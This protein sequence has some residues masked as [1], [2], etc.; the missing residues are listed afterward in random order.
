M[1]VKHIQNRRHLGKDERLRVSQYGDCCLIYHVEAQPLLDRALSG[2]L[3][4][5]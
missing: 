3:F 2:H 4:A 5:P 1:I